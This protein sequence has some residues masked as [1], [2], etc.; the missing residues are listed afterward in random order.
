MVV[1]EETP[2]MRPRQPDKYYGQ[3]D[4]LLLG[5]WIFSVDQYILLTDMP[6]AKQRPFVSTL[7]KNEALLWYKVNYET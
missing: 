1:T 2:S 6:E 3:R 4:F 5:N 7:L